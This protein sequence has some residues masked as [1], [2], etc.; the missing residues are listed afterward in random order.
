MDVD[1]LFRGLPEG[2]HANIFQ[3]KNGFHAVAEKI[4]SLQEKISWFKA[5]HE[6][7]P[8]SDYPLRSFC[9]LHPHTREEAL[10]IAEL[11][12]KANSFDIPISEYYRDKA[13]WETLPNAI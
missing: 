10:F 3:T 8:E 11:A 5:W 7:Y 6:K 9:W 12:L 13:V 1:A 4:V 2:I